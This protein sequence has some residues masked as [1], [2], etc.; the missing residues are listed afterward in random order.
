MKGERQHK[1]L[2]KSA[3]LFCICWKL[4]L[5]S[6]Y[7]ESRPGWPKLTET[8]VEAPARREEVIGIKRLITVNAASIQKTIKR[9]DCN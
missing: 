1:D 7:T 9:T 5:T 8:E 4:A 2:V 6:L 3:R